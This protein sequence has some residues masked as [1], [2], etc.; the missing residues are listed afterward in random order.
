MKIFGGK[1]SI[2]NQK[3][4]ED[5]INTAEEFGIY[6]RSFLT[7]ASFL[8]NKSQLSDRESVFIFLRA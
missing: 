7:I 1:F 5:P 8:Q 6:R 3:Q 4:V 2:T